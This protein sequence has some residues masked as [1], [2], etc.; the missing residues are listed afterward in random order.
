MPLF[1]KGGRRESLFL[2]RAHWHSIRSALEAPAVSQDSADRGSPN[3][4]NP[5]VAKL[6]E[7]LDALLVQ[8]YFA[9]S[10]APKRFCAKDSE[11]Y[12]LHA[13]IE[14]GIERVSGELET[15]GVTIPSL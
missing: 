11:P 14:A 15:L 4:Q 2:V 7:E 8:Q 5:R 1:F 13:E 3:Q 10:R 12:R 6:L 9:D